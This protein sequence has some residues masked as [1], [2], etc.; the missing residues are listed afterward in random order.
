MELRGGRAVPATSKLP[1]SHFRL[2]VLRPIEKSLICLCSI[3][4]KGCIAMLQQGLI[5]VWVFR[6]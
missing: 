1:D 3:S 2:N 4:Y 5:E 6:R